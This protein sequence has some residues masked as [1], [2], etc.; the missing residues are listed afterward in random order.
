MTY[1]PGLRINGVWYRAS[2]QQGLAAAIIT[3][4]IIIMPLQ[5]IMDT[6]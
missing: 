3:A 4:I 6:S 1:G 5:H 2:S